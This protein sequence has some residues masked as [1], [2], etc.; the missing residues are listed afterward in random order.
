[1]FCC[2]LGGAAL[3]V[4]IFKKLRCHL[5]CKD[6]RERFIGS[7]LGLGILLAFAA[8]LYWHHAGGHHH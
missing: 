4:Y 2:T 1:M 5:R 3:S 8:L 7:A 6:K